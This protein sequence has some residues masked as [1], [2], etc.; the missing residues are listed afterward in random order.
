V[1]LSARLKVASTAV[2]I[3][4]TRPA[5]PEI[6]PSCAA[7]P[8]AAVGA[9]FLVEARAQGRVYRYYS[10]ESVTLSCDPSPKSKR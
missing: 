10:D 9:A 5:A 8:T 2:R 3:V 6:R 7:A 4:S 1:A